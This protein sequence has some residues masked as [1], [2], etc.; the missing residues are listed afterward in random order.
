M[1]TTAGDREALLRDVEAAGVSAVI[2]P[3]M[4]KQ[5]RPAP[6]SDVG[7]VLDKQYALFVVLFPCFHRAEVIMHEGCHLAVC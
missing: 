5:A 3:Q 7:A 1:G 6:C 4:G 2:A